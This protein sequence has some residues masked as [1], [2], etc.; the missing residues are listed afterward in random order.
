M[1]SLLL[2]QVPFDLLL[3]KLSLED[4]LKVFGSILLERRIIFLA[5]TLR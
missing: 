4:L 3:S 2:F 5:R 1:T